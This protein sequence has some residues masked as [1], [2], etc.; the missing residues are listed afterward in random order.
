M[1]KLL[2]RAVILLTALVSYAVAGPS[3]PAFA[4]R[5]PLVVPGQILLKAPVGTN[6]DGVRDLAERAGCILLQP[7]AYAP[8][9]YV[10]RLK[11]VSAPT[12]GLVAQPV[13][14]AMMA[15]MSQL[16]QTPGV[17][18]EP[19]Y[20]VRANRQAP[21][22]TPTR[23]IPNDPLYPDGGNASL[24]RQQWHMDMIRMPEAW[25]IQIGVRPVVAAVIDTGIDTT[26]PDFL[27]VDGKT[28][29]LLLAE[30]KNFFDNSVDPTKPID[31]NVTDGD[32]HGTHVAGTVGATTNNALGVVGV[33]GWNRNGV[34]VRILPLRVL[35]NDGGGTTLG[36]ANALYYSA[37]LAS[38]RVDVINLSLGGSFDSTIERDAINAALAANIVVVAAAGNDGQFQSPPQ[39]GFPAD[40]PGVI[41]VSAVDRSRKLAVYSNS[42]GP[43]AIAAPGG[44]GSFNTSGAVL[45][46]WPLSGGEFA[47]NPIFG[48]VAK[49]GYFSIS[50]TS[51]A[52]PHVAGVCALLL[53]AG[54]RPQDVRFLIQSTAQKLDEEP[55]PNGGNQYGAGLIDA[56]AALLP[57]SAPVVR[58]LSP[59]ED[60]STLLRTVTIQVQ[61][62][63]VAKL[64]QPSD[65]T[66]EIRRATIPTTVVRTFVGGRDFTIPAPPD[67]TNPVSP[68]TITLPPVTVPPGEFIVEVRIAGARPSSDSR[69]FTVST[70]TQPVGRALFAVPFKLSPQQAG[71]SREVD[72][73]SGVAFK[74]ARWDPLYDPANTQN[75]PDPYAYFSSTG[76]Q[77]DVTATFSPTRSGLPLTYDTTAGNINDVSA[78]VEPVGLG[79]W[80]D[81]SE[82]QQLN[83]SG[84]TVNN[85]VGIRLYAENGTRNPGGWNLIGSPFTFPVDFNSVSVLFRGTS[86]RLEEAVAQN[87]VK[88]ALVGY[89]Q[90]DYFF[91]IAPQG[92]FQPFNGYWI[93]ALQDCVLIVPPA[94]SSLS[95]S[96]RNV[97]SHMASVAVAKQAASKIAPAGS[98]RGWRVRLQASAAGDRDGQNYF[99]QAVGASAGDDSLDMPKPPSGA[100]HTYLRFVN[101]A[102]AT[103]SGRAAASGVASAYA[104]DLRDLRSTNEEW[105]A[106]VTTDRPNARVTLSW[107]GLG[108][109]PR[110]TRLSLVDTR[111]GQEVSLRARSSYTFQSGEAGE[112]RLF[113]VVQTAEASRGP[114]AVNLTIVRTRSPQQG[115]SVRLTATQDVDLTGRVLT[116][117]GKRVA[118]LGGAGRAVGRR[119]TTLGWDGKGEAGAAVPPGPYVIEVTARTPDGRQTTQVKR[120]FLLLH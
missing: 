72:L 43:V 50:G 83:F 44:D 81:L 114:L 116:L 27:D 74:L 23:A 13:S 59:V 20:V 41:K 113:R 47:S 89:A 33:A 5:A 37:Q 9:W 63:N 92:Q 65:L 109:V 16:A 79:Y 4:Q 87:I 32:G 97:S 54:A 66:I 31:S 40:Y 55:D 70:R 110:S 2:Y 56:Y 99:G 39:P 112:T 49:T 96:V 105:T 75:D 61:V 118:A 38:P 1:R 51:M 14:E 24:I 30:A 95:R 69:F 17:V 111:T 94:A 64:S 119:E 78:S 11:S 108:T 80:L 42:G 90:G 120:S 8:R 58:I 68:V 88:G 82:T 71:V 107:E 53:A 104:F 106:A 46:T 18:A 84:E 73:F 35:G 77:S 48:P 103:G 25:D 6:A 29:R 62:Q 76:T 91:Q 52:S 15:A 57:F 101:R 45:S 26:H 60:Q 117:G 67:P 115:V 93:K 12:T 85:P 102:A 28:S 36:E 86:Y 100:G 19:N 34:N 22:T 98:V 3:R 10:L 21:T 7:A